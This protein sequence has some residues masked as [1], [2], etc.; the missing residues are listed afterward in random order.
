MIR[1]SCPIPP[2]LVLRHPRCPAALRRAWVVTA[3]QA[4]GEIR[5]GDHVFVGT[6]CAAPRTLVQALESAISPP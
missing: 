2:S 4:V 6:G 1:R 3:E 5:N